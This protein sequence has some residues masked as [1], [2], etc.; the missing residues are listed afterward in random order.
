MP[1]PRE[2]GPTGPWQTW[3]PRPVG[4]PV[5][6]SR[7]VLVLL[8]ACAFL[9]ITVEAQA[10]QED[11]EAGEEPSCVL[12]WTSLT[13]STTSRSVEIDPD[14]YR[15]HVWHGMRWTCGDAVMTADS[16]VQF[17]GDRVEMVGSVTYRDTV[18][19]LDARRLTYHQRTDLIEA[20]DSVRLVRTATGSTLEAPQVDFYRAGTG[21]IRQTV[22]DGGTRMQV[23][24]AGEEGG[25]GSGRPYRITADRTVILRDD[26]TVAIGDV[27][28]TRE[29]LRGTG[30]YGRFEPDGTGFLTEDPVLQGE[31]YRL[32]GD[33]VYTTSV[34]GRMEEVRSAGAAHLE[35]GGLDVRAPEIRIGFSEGT[36][37]DLRAYGGG[38]RS[39]SASRIML[40]DSLHIVF[41]EDR[42]DSATAVGRAAALELEGD[43][44]LPV[45]TAAAD[46]EED[47]AAEPGEG[48]DPSPGAAVEDTTAV[49]TGEDTTAAP[50]GAGEGTPGTPDP[51]A[52]LFTVDRDWI[53]GDTVRAR[54]ATAGDSAADGPD[55]QVTL[56][57]LTALGGA[58]AYYR[59]SRDT[60]SDRRGRNYLL[61]REIVVEF[62]EGDPYRV[63]GLQAIGV[64]LEPA[65]AGAA[66]S[67]GRLPPADTG[68]AGPPVDTTTP[69][70]TTAPPDT[71]LASPA[72]REVPK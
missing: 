60:A 36:V 18:R 23:V 22:A 67:P 30:G 69:P 27:V 64:Y 37:R 7:I 57:S 59:I 10:Q 66:S 2:R 50:T 34:E 42:P 41:G 61:G 1:E 15:H 17:P 32:T 55:G 49:P 21:E 72:P 35:S 24:P 12:R 40:G 5:R 31:D 51:A 9:A 14:R 11:Q 45:D 20:R 56:R 4:R 26:E 48:D 62:R 13:D 44:E 70:D 29:D 8:S 63:T 28:I 38:A 33:T 39:R 19:T 6:R 52:S 43:E 3:S 58:R 16:A 71:T 46:E 65:G 25:D 68:A 47:P 54:F 53:R